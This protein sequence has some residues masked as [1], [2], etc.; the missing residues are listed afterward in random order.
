MARAGRAAL[1]GR[2]RGSAL[3]AVVRDKE[4]CEPG[5]VPTLPVPRPGSRAAGSPPEPA[6]T[7]WEDII[8]EL[9]MSGSKFSFRKCGAIS[10][11]GAL[12]DLD[13]SSLVVTPI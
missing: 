1:G 8:C 5:H 2:H 3:I 9:R 13:A 4:H 7:F 6:A 11:K 12:I 10:R